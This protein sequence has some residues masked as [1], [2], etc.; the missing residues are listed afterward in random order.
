MLNNKI[1]SYYGGN[2]WKIHYPLFICIYNNSVFLN[3]EWGSRLPLFGKLLP[4]SPPCSNIIAV[5][6]FLLMQVPSLVVMV[7]NWTV[8]SADSRKAC[9]VVF[10]HGLVVEGKV[11]VQNLAKAGM[12]SYLSLKPARELK[13]AAEAYLKNS[14]ALAARL[15]INIF[16]SHRW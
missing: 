14:E 11:E 9:K 15:F 5:Q 3:C 12:I 13:V 16:L 6:N 2:N 1:Y 8:L 4:P 7:N 10:E